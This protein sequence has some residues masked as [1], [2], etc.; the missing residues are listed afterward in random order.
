MPTFADLPDHACLLVRTCQP[1][2]PPAHAQ[3]LGHALDLLFAQF[4]REKRCSSHAAGTTADGHLVLAAWMGAPLS[5]CAHDRLAGLFT[6]WGGRFGCDLLTAPPLVV[7]LRG[8]VR[9]LD[10]RALREL[11]QTADL[12]TA[13]T[14]DTRAETLGAWRAGCGQPLAG[15]WIDRALGLS[16]PSRLARS[17]MP[18]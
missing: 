13:T 5:G 16:Q 1:G 2:L 3:R 17:A 6:V 8:Q 7:A 4:A 18:A 12:T 10:R 15:S 11:A 14:W 9:T